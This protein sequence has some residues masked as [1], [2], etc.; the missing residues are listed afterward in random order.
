[1]ESGSVHR[2]QGQYSADQL[3]DGA[4]AKVSWALNVRFLAARG[5]ARVESSHSQ[6]RIRHDLGFSP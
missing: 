2:G 3:L 6:N 1:M 4:T 5:A